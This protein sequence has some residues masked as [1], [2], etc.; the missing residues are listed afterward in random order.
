MTTFEQVL[1]LLPRLSPSERGRILELLEADPQIAAQRA[2]NQVAL[3]HLDARV[4]AD[5]DEDD[6]WWEEFARDLDRDRLSNRPLYS[7]QRSPVS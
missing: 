6:S 1:T 7:D 3:A 5:D 4:A 2:A